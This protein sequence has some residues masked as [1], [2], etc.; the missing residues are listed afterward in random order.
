MSPTISRRELI[1]LA[2]G[3]GPESPLHALVKSMRTRREKRGP[4]GLPPSL[5]RTL[6]LVVPMPDS[7]S[8]A[9][10]KSRHW[11]T[12]A[13]NKK[14]YFRML[15]ERRKANLIPEPPTP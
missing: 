4:I 9:S 2:K 12:I 15:D 10:G 6:S 5:G 13:T 8:N 3:A 1:E 11:R 7:L 14:R